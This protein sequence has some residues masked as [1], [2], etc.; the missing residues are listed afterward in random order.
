MGEIPEYGTNTGTTTEI[1]MQIGVNEIILMSRCRMGRV[2]N[3]DEEAGW[4]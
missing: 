3:K 2:R 1:R 4:D